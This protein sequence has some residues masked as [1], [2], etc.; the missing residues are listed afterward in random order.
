[1]AGAALGLDARSV[2]DGVGH[3]ACLEAPDAWDA[4]VRGWLSAVG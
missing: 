4:A 2:L 1:M 3:L